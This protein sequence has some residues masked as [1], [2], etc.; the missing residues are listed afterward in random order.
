VYKAGLG[1]ALSHYGFP[2]GAVVIG[3]SLMHYSLHKAADLL[4]IGSDNVILLPT[5]GDHRIDLDALREAVARCRVGRRCILAIVGIAGTTDT[6]SIDPLPEMAEIA[7]EAGVH[8]HVDAAWGGPTLF[9]ERY[10]H[11]VAGIECADSVVIDGHKQ[12]YLPIGIGMVL[13]RDPRCARAIEKEAWYILRAGSMDLGKRSLEGSRPSM[14]IFVQGALHILGR[15]GYEFLIDEGIHKARY[16]AGAIGARAEFELLAEPDLNIV[17]YRYVPEAFRENLTAGRLSEQA[18]RA[19]SR[20]NEF[21]QEA[22]F[23][24]GRSFVSRTTLRTTQYGGDPGVTALRAVLA[25]PLT[26]RDDIDAVL[27][28]QAELGRSLST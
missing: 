9:S 22:Q 19:I 17:V 5:Q 25:N 24:A 8:F 12:M 14:A 26:T 27:T 3:S 11:R 20:C 23:E 10:R 21:L 1:A 7:A 4:G 15:K 16:M 13:L 18:N 28:E 2:G 6:G